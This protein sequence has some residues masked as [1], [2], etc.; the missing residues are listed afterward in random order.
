VLFSILFLCLIGLTRFFNLPWQ[1]PIPRLWG[2]VIGLTLFAVGFALMISALKALGKRALGKNLYQPKKESKLITTG[3]YAYTRNPIMLAATLLWLGWF[4]I[5]RLTF[6]LIVT[7][8]FM[9]LAYVGVIQ[10][11]EKELTERFG[12]EYLRYKETVPRF[13][14]SL[15]KRLRS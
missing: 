5:F 7:F 4:F 14:P 2:I 3:P 15:K 6:L 1:V 13:I 8:L 11:E 10:W 9:I 12:G